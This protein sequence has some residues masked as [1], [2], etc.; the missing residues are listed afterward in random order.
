MRARHRK[1][2]IYYFLD[3][4]GKDRKEIALGKDYVVAVQRWAELTAKKVPASGTITFRYV[5]ECYVRDILPGKRL[6]TQKDNLRELGWLYKF[7]DDPPVPLDDI[8][9]SDVQAYLKWRT[10]K[11]RGNREKALLSHIWN[12]ARG[13]GL[14][15]K[16]NP[17]AGIKGN[18]ETGRD[19]YIDD[20]IYRLVWAAAEEPLKDALDLAYLTGQRPGDVF[21][22]LH[23][24]IKDGAIWVKQ[25]K[26]GAKV[27]VSVV[28]DLKKVLNRITGRKVVGLKLLNFSFRGAFDRARAAAAEA[29]PEQAKDIWEFQF[30]DLRAKAG[31]DK[32]E[33]EGIIAAQSQLGHSSP[34]MTAHYVRHRKGKLVGPTK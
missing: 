10:A 31:T 20:A 25:G 27:R 32:E 8:E 12:Y 5:A 18:K 6:T 7:F 28:G 2:V 11:I 16:M 19:I 22:M 30:R 26:T 29:N 14:T 4:G 15:N 1:N 3:T 23:S 21:K 9:P 13:A 17:C 33:V 24:D 34:S